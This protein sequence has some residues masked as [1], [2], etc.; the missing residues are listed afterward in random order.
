MW[1]AWVG[2]LRLLDAWVPRSTS[3]VVGAMLPV[4]GVEAALWVLL[5]LAAGSA[6]ELAFRGYLLQ[7][8]GVVGQALVF[9]ILHAYQGL[10]SM[11]RITVYGLMFGVVAR[12]RRSLVPG[13]LAHAWTDIAAGLF[14]W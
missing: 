11:V 9:G 10:A 13:M 7:K 4:G 12:R 14:R 5:A 3:E 8:I 6:E 1:V 2:V